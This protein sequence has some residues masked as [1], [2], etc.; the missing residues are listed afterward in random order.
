VV[1]PLQRFGNFPRNSSASFAQYTGEWL[2]LTSHD[3]NSRKAKTTNK[4]KIKMKRLNITFGTILLVLGCFAFSPAAKADP[5]IAGL[6]HEY[7]TSDFGPPFE[8][9]AQWHND[10]LEIETPNFLNGVCMGTWKQ[11]AGRTFKLFHVGW[12]PGGIPPAPTSVRFE[13]RHL[14][15]VSVNGNS[16][17][18][19]YDQKFFDAN[20]NLVFE[21]MGTIHA[22]RLSVDQFAESNP[23]ARR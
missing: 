23:T 12:T 1:F 16:F 8:T 4:R 15:T 6:W 11:I 5:P 14:D 17:D 2:E 10:G 3:E 9:Y 19:T 7:Y 22:T 20:G 21:D 13:L 18:G